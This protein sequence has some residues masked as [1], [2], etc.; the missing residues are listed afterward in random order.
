MTFVFRERIGVE[1]WV[2]LD[3]TYIFSNE[4]E[5]HEKAL[6]YVLN[7][8]KTEQLYISENKFKP[9]TIWFNSLGHYRDENGLHASMDKLDLI[10]RWSTPALL[11]DVQQFLGL[12]E[13]ISR[14]LPNVSAYTTPLSGI[15]SQGLMFQWRKLYDKCFKSIKAIA[16]RKLSLK[17]VDR[18]SKE[19]IWVVTDAC[20]SGCSAYY[21]QGNDWKTMRPAGFMLKKFTDAQRAYFTYEHKTLRVIEALKK[22][23]NV[24]LGMPKIRIITDHKALKTFMQKSH[25]G[26][27]QIRWSQWL[28]R[29][30]L[31]IIHI[32][33]QQN[34]S[35]D[36]LSRIYKNPNSKPRLEDLS[37]VDLL[38]DADGD[39]LPTERIE[40]KNILHIAAMTCAQQMCDA[41]KP[42]EVE[43]NTMHPQPQETQQSEDQQNMAENWGSEL[44]V[45][46]S[47]KNK[48]FKPFM[49]KQNV[50]GKNIPDLEKLCQ[51][52][53]QN[54]QTFWKIIKHPKDHK[55]FEVTNGVIYHKT[56]TNNKVICIPKSNVQGRRLTELV[57]NQAHRIVGHLGTNN[58]K[59]R[60]AI[61]LVDNTGTR[62]KGIL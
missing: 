34:R 1:V 49:W 26:P 61:V 23:D 36:A 10:R 29:F 18:N 8:L 46:N 47:T 24:F 40:E 50:G 35:A 62:H 15:C 43:A 7:C 38:L 51:N 44:T 25:M 57:I 56:N 37:N 32:P 42:Q 4:I 22:W 28:T 16:S 27:R 39:D 58:Q 11:Q 53:Y 54:D 21:G 41:I 14:F 13:Y 5:N 20:P 12:V 2:Y 17:L 9:Y 55:S 52:A 59:L 19:P 45:T 6:Q 33:G 31:K 30:R 3:D 48:T 60:T